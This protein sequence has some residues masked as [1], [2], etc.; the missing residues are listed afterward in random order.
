MYCHD[1][2][3]RLRAVRAS[4]R[5]PAGRVCDAG[6]DLATG[7][8][9]R[10]DGGNGQPPSKELPRGREDR[11]PEL[12]GVAPHALACDCCAGI[13]RLLADPERARQDA[14]LREVDAW[15]AGRAAAHAAEM[16]AG[17]DAGECR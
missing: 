1:T 8:T 14:L 4:D 6:H 16:R 7:L 13:R 10:T 11:A 12:P 2:N 15:F 17:S 9:G 3:V 5:P